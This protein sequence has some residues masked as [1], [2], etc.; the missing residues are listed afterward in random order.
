MSNR[1][2][3]LAAA[4]AAGPADPNFNQTVL[5][6]HGDGTNGAQN[7]TFL[8]S[9]TNNFTI[10]RN[11]NTTQGTFSP[12]SL[13]AGEFSNFFDG[14]G[15]YLDLGSNAAFAFG[16][17]DYTIELWYYANGTSGDGLICTGTSSQSSN[18]QLRVNA[19]T[20]EIV[21]DYS[22]G[23]SITGPSI[24]TNTWTHIAAT[25]SGTTVTLWVNGVSAGTATSSNDLSSQQFFIGRN[26]ANT[27]Q[28]N[29]YISNARL[30]KGTALYSGAF[31]PSTAPLTAIANTSLLTCQSNRFVD[32]SSNAFAI[33][34][35]GN[36]SVQ[37][38]SPFLPSAAYSASVNGGSGYFSANGD[39]LST[40]SAAIP[41]SADFTIELWI[42][43]TDVSAGF[44]DT[45]GLV[46]QFTDETANRMSLAMD[47]GVPYLTTNGTDR[48]TSSISVTENAWNYIALVRDSG[49]D[50]LY[51][52]AVSGGTAA[53]TNIQQTGLNI[54]RFLAG[55]RDRTFRGYMASLRISDN[56]RT[57]TLPTAPYT[58][59]ANVDFLANFTNAGIFDNTG[60]NN[61]ETVGNAQVDTS[62]KK[63]GTGSLEF[64]GTGDWLLL[65]NNVNQQL[66]T[67]NFTI[68]FWVYLATG[69]TGSNRGLVAKGGASTGFLV[70]LNTT[71][72]VVFTFT[73][74]TITSTGAITTNAWNH[75]AVVRE[76]TGS[77]QTKIYIAGTN[78]GTG[79]VSTDF[80]QTSVMYVGA[81]RTGGD[82]MKG[83]IDD[84]RITKGVA[85]YT[86]N[87][88]PPTAAFPNL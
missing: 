15:D 9:S 33:T 16:T 88:T 30:L 62:V 53:S 13:A 2:L 84:L 81:N 78:D 35:N 22:A 4:G 59:D 56:V 17:G 19:S 57:I 28:A 75:I 64:D 26:R 83:Y 41:T 39:Y 70:S 87:F 60:K 24:T 76:G 14:S 1:N 36:T 20:A 29:G 31:T 27:L 48:I 6:L 55:G 71:Q 32:N 5:L 43:P 21:F 25:R 82:P 10:T 42:Y 12:F 74:S 23:N 79:T 34:V 46:S 51:V 54:G 44:N 69:D 3:I 49:T 47:N 77:N 50:T 65:A 63:Y 73:S 85:R 80:N 67:G 58:N 8:D 86:A 37:P 38:F 11:G 52:N 68:E 18:W 40:A 7:N 61:L 66:G 45:Q 72:K